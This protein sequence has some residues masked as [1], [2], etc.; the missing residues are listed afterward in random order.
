[1]KTNNKENFGI[2]V[3]NPIIKIKAE[4]EI[5]EDVTKLK[6]V[7]DCE[8]IAIITMTRGYEVDVMYRE[9]KDRKPFIDI[10]FNVNGDYEPLDNITFDSIQEVID[11]IES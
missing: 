3:N 4:V 6:N 11:Y 2:F 10:G 7:T 9:P 5:K 8:C 1:M